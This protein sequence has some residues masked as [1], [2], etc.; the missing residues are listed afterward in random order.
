MNKQAATAPI[1]WDHKSS[2]IV[3]SWTW[4]TEHF[5][6]TIFEEGLAARKM[7]NWK[8]TDLSTG[9]PVIFDHGVAYD[10]SEAVDG[11][12]ELI[13]KSYPAEYGYQAYAGK[14]ATTFEISDGNKYDFRPA[15]GQ[16]VIAKVYDADNKEITLTGIFNVLHYDFTLQSSGQT[17]I[18]P[19]M[20]VIDILKEFGMSSLIK[21]TYGDQVARSKSGRIVYEEW[22]KGCT[23]KPGFKPGTT[24]HPPGSLYCSIHGV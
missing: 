22:Q 21:T 20:K 10:F 11:I 6:V 18:L 24:I 14:L 23:G 1:P 2:A 9:S 13:G 7:Y 19:P 5:T 4:N 16:S 17:I 8:I 12:L 15:I 3:S